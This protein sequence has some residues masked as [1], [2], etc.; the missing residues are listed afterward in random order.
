M[1]VM[2]API[3]DTSDAVN[4]SRGIQYL[5]RPETERAAAAVA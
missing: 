5:T 3:C 4:T 1:T 2:P